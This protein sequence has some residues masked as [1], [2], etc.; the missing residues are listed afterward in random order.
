M[1]FATKTT[2]HVERL[3][4]AT[5]RRTLKADAVLGVYVQVIQKGVVT[6]EEWRGLS[7]TDAD[8][9]DVNTDASTL[10]GVVRAWLG[11]VRVTVA[12]GNASSWFTV[13]ACWGTEVRTEIA[14]VGD[15][16]LFDVFRRTT[17]YSVEVPGVAAANIEYT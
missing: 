16:D 12:S 9:L 2:G 11:G 13:F 6:T 4:K 8:S 1:G 17:V 7:R 14:R 3:R 10:G 15:T 5:D